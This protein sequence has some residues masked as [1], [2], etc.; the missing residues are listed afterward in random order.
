MTDKQMTTQEIVKNSTEV[1]QNDLDWEQVY[2]ALH[3]SIASN[4]YRMFRQGNT[5]FWIR[6]DEPGVAQMFV[7][8]ADSYKNLLRNTRDFMQAMHRAHYQTIYGETIDINLLNYLKREGFPVDIQQIG[9]DAKMRTLYK[10]T[11]NV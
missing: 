6:I 8:N 10:G 11:I 4:K 7:L 3:K 9:Q 1:K 5:L 2:V